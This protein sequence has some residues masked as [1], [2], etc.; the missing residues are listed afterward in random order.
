M[1]FNF[2][3]Q[4]WGRLYKSFKWP[5]VT[6][7]YNF[8]TSCSGLYIASFIFNQ[9]INSVM[10]FWCS[11]T[12]DKRCLPGDVSSCTLQDCLTRENHC[13]ALSPWLCCSCWVGSGT[14]K[15]PLLETQQGFLLPP[16]PI[17]TL[18]P[19]VTRWEWQEDTH[20]KSSLSKQKRQRRLVVTKPPETIWWS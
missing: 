6:K 12:H 4:G 17:S 3:S 8:C 14:G 18:Q 7:C 20:P 2:S 16:E 10:H 13:P 19:C 11:S 5:S 1:L 15:V 9:C